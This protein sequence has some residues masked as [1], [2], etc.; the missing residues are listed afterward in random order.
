MCFKNLVLLGFLDDIITDETKCAK[1]IYKIH[2]FNA[3]YGWMAKCQG[4]KP[5]HRGCGV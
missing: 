2:G 3:W 4:A 5:D 1:L